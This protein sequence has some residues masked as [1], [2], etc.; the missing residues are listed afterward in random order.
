MNGDFTGGICDMA[1]EWTFRTLL[2]DMGRRGQ[3]PA[4]INVRAATLHTISFD[5]LVSIYTHC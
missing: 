3:A 2:D 5:E 4:L 1:D